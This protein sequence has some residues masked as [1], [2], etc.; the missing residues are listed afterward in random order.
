MF[1]IQFHTGYNIFNHRIFCPIFIKK[2]RRHYQQIWIYFGNLVIYC[3]RNLSDLRCICHYFR[4]M[5]DWKDDGEDGNAEWGIINIVL[6]YVLHKA[7]AV[8]IAANRSTTPNI[9]RIGGARPSKTKAIKNTMTDRRPWIVKR[10]NEISSL[11]AD[12]I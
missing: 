2:S 7:N 8:Q 9:I 3:C 4:A 6:Y 11:R 12:C 5:S 1:S 10:K